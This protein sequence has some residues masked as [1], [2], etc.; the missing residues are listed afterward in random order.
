M[1]ASGH[2]AY[3]YDA[4]TGEVLEGYSPDQE[5]AKGGFMLDASIGKSIYLSGGKRLSI[6]L[7]VQNITNNTNMKTGGY[8]QNRADRPYDYIF[9][10]N[11]FY[12]YANAI[13]AF[14]NVSLK[15]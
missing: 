7:Q 3:V 5:K 1:A 9:S 8:E 11:N 12:Y 2:A 6:N 14:L 13:N 4:Q 10:R 15:F